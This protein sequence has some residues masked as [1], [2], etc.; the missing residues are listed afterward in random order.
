MDSLQYLQPGC[1][2][3]ILSGIR[4]CLMLALYGGFTA[5]IVSVFMI[6]DEENPEVR[7]NFF[8]FSVA[9]IILLLN[10]CSLHPSD[11]EGY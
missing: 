4:Y 8:F 2:F 3:F 5:V 10:L 7:T 11:S 1:R 6:E 9:R